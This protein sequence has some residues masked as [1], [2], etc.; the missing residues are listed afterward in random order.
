[1]QPKLAAKEIAFT[2]KVRFTFSIEKN[3]KTKDRNLRFIESNSCFIMSVF[4]SKILEVY[5]T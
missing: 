3:V 1:M 5:N 2:Q 4:N